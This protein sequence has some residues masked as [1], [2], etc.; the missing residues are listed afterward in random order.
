[1]MPTQ[2]VPS[3]VPVFADAGAKSP[4]LGDQL[5]A[6][7]AVQILVHIKLSPGADAAWRA[8]AHK[9]ILPSAKADRKASAVAP[10]LRVEVTLARLERWRLRGGGR[11]DAYS[12]P[13]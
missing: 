5:L 2:R 10:R 3:A 1:M 12:L 6:A 7:Q 11:A 13:L 9:G 4:Y 8:G